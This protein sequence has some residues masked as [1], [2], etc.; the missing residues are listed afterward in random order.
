MGLG[1][2]IDSGGEWALEIEGGAD[3]AVPG[4]SLRHRPLHCLPAH[5]SAKR[6]SLTRGA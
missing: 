6:D 1:G 2:I 4:G 3:R 5:R